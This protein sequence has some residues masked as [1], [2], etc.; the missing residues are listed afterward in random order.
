MTLG[1]SDRILEA[2]RLPFIRCGRKI[3]KNSGKSGGHEK[4]TAPSR[5]LV[6]QADSFYQLPT[7]SQVRDF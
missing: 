4:Y 3:P 5:C 7:A 1:S 6:L 2:V